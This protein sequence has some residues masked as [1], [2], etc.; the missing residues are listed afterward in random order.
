MTL[1]EK[2][3]ANRGFK[4]A[5]SVKARKTTEQTLPRKKKPEKE[6]VF[7]ALSPATLEIS[8]DSVKITGFDIPFID[9]VWFM[10]K[11]SFAAIPAAIIIVLI[12]F[13]IL[14]FIPLLGI[15]IPMPH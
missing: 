2:N 11:A 15:V 5:K 9:M 6:K 13:L 3:I 7:P 1:Q 10:V 4:N 14:I 8:S 12:W